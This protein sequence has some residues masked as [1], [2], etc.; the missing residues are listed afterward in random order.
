MEDKIP[1]PLWIGK[2]DVA[3]RQLCE[4]I[5]LLFSERDPVAI[6]TLVAAAHQ[7]LFDIGKC[8]DVA[9]I[10]KPIG[11]SSPSEE[12]DHNKLIN[13]AINFMKHA[14]KD[15]NARINISPL[16]ILAQDL[17]MDAV[18]MLQC[19]DGDLPIEAKTFWTWFV[20]YR[21][22]EFEGA[23]PAIDS[24][25]QQDLASW[26]FPQIA[27]FLQFA[28]IIGDQPMNNPMD[29]TPGLPT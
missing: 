18:R 8:Q 3:R 26:D 4:A 10:V 28:D 1:E 19:I 27:M 7:V 15:P 5:R 6:H 24:M 12:A 9:S 2:I 14:D 23:G 21:R 22:D 11:K 16:S 17:L 25:I 29:R 20:S 13:S